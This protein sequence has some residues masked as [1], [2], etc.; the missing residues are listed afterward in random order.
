MDQWEFYVVKT[1]VLNE[2][3]QNR[4]SISLGD[5][6]KITEPVLYNNLNSKILEIRPIIIGITKKALSLHLNSNKNENSVRHLKRLHSVAFGNSLPL[7]RR[8]CAVWQ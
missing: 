4:T 8:G 3:Y 2:K 7:L 6:Q 5:L 1:T